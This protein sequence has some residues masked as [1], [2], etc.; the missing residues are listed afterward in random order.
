MDVKISFIHSLNFGVK[1]DGGRDL[2]K[3]GKK[4]YVLFSLMGQWNQKNIS[5]WNVTLSKTSGTV[6]AIYVS[7]NSVALSFQ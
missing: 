7:I 6:T 4:G 3:L 2:K 5:F 1:Q